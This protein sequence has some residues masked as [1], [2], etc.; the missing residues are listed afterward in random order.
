MEK[1]LVGSFEDGYIGIA[2]V[3]IYIMKDDHPFPII[4]SG[5]FWRVDVY[6]C[7]GVFLAHIKAS[8]GGVPE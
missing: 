8:L 5:H 2:G 1:T 7:H 3:N 4:C 6:G